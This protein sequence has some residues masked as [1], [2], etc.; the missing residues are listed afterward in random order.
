VGRVHGCRG[1]RANDDAHVAQFRRY[2]AHLL[3]DGG[4]EVADTVSPHGGVRGE[5]QDVRVTG[6]HPHVFRERAVEEGGE[7][8]VEALLAAGAA[9]QRAQ[10][11][12]AGHE[13]VAQAAH[14][15]RLRTG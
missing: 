1:R 3:E 15:I 6:G 8:G 10:R 5:D 11:R 13:Q 7:R 4:R 14:G 12:A 9:H 2:L